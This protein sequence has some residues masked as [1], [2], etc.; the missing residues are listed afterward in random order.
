VTAVVALA[1]TPLGAFA[2][3]VLSVAPDGPIGAAGPARPVAR[4]SASAPYAASSEPSA[5]ERCA[6]I[7]SRYQ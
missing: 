6:A 4:S 5:R 3:H 2:Y 7:R 1:L